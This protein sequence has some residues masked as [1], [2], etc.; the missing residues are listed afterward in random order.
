MKKKICEDCICSTC[1]KA[2]SEKCN[3]CSVC[4]IEE[5]D[6]IEQRCRDYVRRQ[7]K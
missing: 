1:L 6:F 7:N 3:E 4:K 2:N 5:V